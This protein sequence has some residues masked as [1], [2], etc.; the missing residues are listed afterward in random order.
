MSGSIRTAFLRAQLDGVRGIQS[1]SRLVGSCLGRH[2]PEAIIEEAL[3]GRSTRLHSSTT[4]FLGGSACCQSSAVPYYVV[5]NIRC[6]G[7]V[8]IHMES[9]RNAEAFA[10]LFTRPYLIHPRSPPIG[11]K[12]AYLRPAGLTRESWLLLS[13]NASDRVRRVIAASY[14]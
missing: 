4:P 12:L 8:P 3:F 1:D 7:H 5:R 10:R 6:Y 14:F 2:Y 11:R 13:V 9:R